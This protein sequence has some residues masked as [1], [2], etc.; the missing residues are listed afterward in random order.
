MGEPRWVLEDAPT[1]PS[2]AAEVADLV[3]VDAWEDGAPWDWVAVTV[4][5]IVVMADERGL[6]MTAVADAAGLARPVVKDGPNP[7]ALRRAVER[8]RAEVARG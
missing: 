7:D 8:V 3:P 4:D 1:G 6:V 5:G 2:W